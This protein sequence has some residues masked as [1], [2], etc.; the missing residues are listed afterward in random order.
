MTFLVPLENLCE[1]QCAVLS[2]S[3]TYSY[4]SASLAS[5]GVV[6]TREKYCAITDHGFEKAW[7]QV[8]L[9][10]QFSLKSIKIFLPYSLKSHYEGDHHALVKS[11]DLGK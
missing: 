7:L 2:Q 6:S 5:D 3:S 9:G 11:F 8:D 10:R 4:N 1:R